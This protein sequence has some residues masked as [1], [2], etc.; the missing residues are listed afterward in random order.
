MPCISTTP[1]DQVAQRTAHN[2]AVASTLLLDL[3]HPQLSRRLDL[4][5]LANRA[6]TLLY[7]AEKEH[8]R[9]AGAGLGE[10]EP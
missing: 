10:R 6:G 2:P 9:V 7:V 5:D 8:N 1:R 4:A 3:T